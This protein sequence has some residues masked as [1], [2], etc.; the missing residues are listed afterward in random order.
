MCKYRKYYKCKFVCVSIAN[1]IN[2]IS[3]KS[4]NPHREVESCQ[5]YL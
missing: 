2:V 4:N 3:V 5:C 1:I